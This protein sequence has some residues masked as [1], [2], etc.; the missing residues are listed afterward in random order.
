MEKREME[1][2][3]KVIKRMVEELHEEKA[4]TN[5]G[6]IYMLYGIVFFLAAIS[7]QVFVL[8]RV[9]STKP[10]WIAW[11]SAL[12]V[13]EAAYWLDEARQRRRIRVRSYL[14][15]QISWV[16]NMFCV[17]MGVT[18]FAIYA[19]GSHPYMY[20]LL[21]S[22]L[23]ILFAIT[24]SVNGILLGYN[25]QLLALSAIC[26]A[27]VIPMNLIPRFMA[28]IFGVL[29]LLGLGLPGLTMH[30]QWLAMK[31]ETDARV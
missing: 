16:W 27:G 10:F 25:R 8:L 23:M 18:F 22:F 28:G 30:R 3:V 26:F 5:W 14:E 19:H 2:G 17:A 11:I 21:W 12:V 20:F 1:E 29:I 24:L 4:K 13:V 31:K 9:R 6:P 15:R 7:C